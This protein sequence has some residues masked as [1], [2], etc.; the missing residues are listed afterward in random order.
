MW[1]FALYIGIFGTTMIMFLNNSRI[2]CSFLA[3]Y[4]QG[5]SLDT[6]VVQSSPCGAETAHGFWVQAYGDVRTI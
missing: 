4:S 5:Y 3:A 6:Y 2:S 1:V